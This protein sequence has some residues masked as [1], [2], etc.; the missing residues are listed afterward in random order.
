MADLT[1]EGWTVIVAAGD[2]PGGDGMAHHF[3][4]PAKALIPVA[5][6][7]MVSRVARALT[8]SPNVARIVILAQNT[9][10]LTA[11]A[12][13]QWLSQEP[14]ISF[15]TSAGSLS[16]S[17]SAVAGTEIAPWP[18]LVTTADHPLL[19]P[20]MVDAF[21]KNSAGADLAVGFVERKTLLADFPE[22]KRTWLK[23]SDG[24][25]SGANLFAFRGPAVKYVLEFWADVESRRKSPLA[26]F[27]RFGPWLLLR[28]VTRTISLE[29][30]LR[31]AGRRLG[32]SA[33]PVVLPFAEAAIDV[34]KMS[35]HALAEEI[36]K[37]RQS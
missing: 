4:E 28:A 37:G 3:G 29:A 6:E 8:Q 25:F 24:F 1:P 19:T 11:K 16:Q 7:S 2:R 18:V 14:R 31:N 17:L 33:K 12:D 15:A 9:G 22:N 10:P 23:F 35:D 13:T 34:D 27:R 36:L 32:V 21:L 5:G 20:A 26:I 30:G